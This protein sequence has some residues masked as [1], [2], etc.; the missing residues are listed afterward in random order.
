[1][2]ELEFK[3]EQSKEKPIYTQPLCCT[4]SFV[5]Y[6]NAILNIKTKLKARAV[7]KPSFAI[8]GDIQ[9]DDS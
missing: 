3:P 4:G 9:P 2:V 5:V 8:T 6:Q 7:S 1:M